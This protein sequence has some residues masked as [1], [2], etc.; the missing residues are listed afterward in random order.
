MRLGNKKGFEMA[1]T[2]LVAIALG[3]IMDEIIFVGTKIRGPIEYTSTFSSAIILAI[4]SLLI[5][6]FIFYV[7]KKKQ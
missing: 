3:L 1:I 7:I 4:I 6:D 5:I 2:T